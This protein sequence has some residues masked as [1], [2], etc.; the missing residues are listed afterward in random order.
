VAEY[1]RSPA[2]RALIAASAANARNG[3]E[4]LGFLSPEYGFL[5]A[6]PPLQALPTS[7]GA[8]DELAQQL[9]ELYRTL[10]LRRTLEAL[11]ELPADAAQLPD[12]YLLRASALLSILAH[13]YHRVEPTPPARLPQVLQ[14]PWE[15][16]SRRLG[17][18]TTVLSYIDLI[19]YNWRL[20]D[21]GHLHPHRVENMALLI[22]TVDNREEQIFYLTQVEIL[23]RCA[24]LVE[25][26]V[27]AQEAALRD[28]P[29]ALKAELA[30]IAERL[31]L[32]AHES[33]VK[34]DPNPT[35]ATYV[36]PVVWAKTVA[37]FAVPLFEGVQGPSGT[38]SPIFNLLDLFFGRRDYHSMLGQ[39]IMHLRTWYP[40][41]WQTFLAAV[42][43][44]STREY[45]ERKGDRELTGF[46][47]AAL[48]AYAGEDGFLGRHRLK[49][50]GYLE[51]AFK[52]GRSVTIGGFTGLF[53]DRT[54]DTV[55]AALEESRQERLDHVEAGWHQATV[56]STAHSPLGANSTARHVALYVRGAGLTYQP[57]DRCCVLPEN[58]PTLIARTLAALQATGDEVVGL[59][60]IWRDALA[61]REGYATATELPL[62]DLLRFGEIRPVRRSVARGL[63]SAT[64][65]QA[66]RRIIDARA[67]DQWELWDLLELLTVAGFDPRVLWRAHPSDRE[68]VCWVVPPLRYRMYSIVSA[69]ESGMAADEIHLTVGGMRYQTQAT[70]VSNEAT[71][72]GTAS[73]FLMSLEEGQRVAVKIVHPPRFSLP[74]DFTRPIVM[75]AGGTGLAPFRSFLQARARQPDAGPAWL[76]FATR[77][78]EELYYA[79]DL[80][81]HVANGRLTLQVALS[82]EERSVRVDD[83]GQIVLDPARSRRIDD[84]LLQEDNAAL[85]GRL[86]RLDA[87]DGGAVVYVCGRAGFADTVQRTLR[88]LLAKQLP[89]TPADQARESAKL[90][91]KLVADGRYREEVYTSYPGPTAAASLQIDASEIVLHNDA[92]RDAWVVISGRVYDLTEFLHLHPGGA[93]ILRAYLGMDA[94]HA[95][96]Q[97]LHHVRPEVDALLAMY[98]IGVVRRL[99]FGAAWTVI[100]AGSGLRFMFLADAYKAW[101]RLLYLVVEMENA[102]HLDFG[103]RQSVTTGQ[104]PLVAHTPYTLQLVLEV[105]QRFSASYLYGLSGEPLQELWTI[106]CGLGG[107][108]ENVDWM[109]EVLDALLQS[110][111]A[112]AVDSVVA[113]LVE[114]VQGDM[115]AETL[116][117]GVAATQVLEA[118]DRTFLHELKLAI[119]DGVQIFETYERDTAAH[120]GVRLLDVC[121]RLADLYASFFTRLREALQPYA[122][123]SVAARIATSTSPTL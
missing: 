117:R 20:C 62:H 48:N 70:T 100:V 7:H 46:F 31:H 27:R 112:R 95:Y 67:E 16:V 54:W 73:T 72:R 109:R 29:P 106:A 64:G 114:S 44:Y 45:I 110:E 10:R 75:I 101:V 4:N 12:T 30:G 58:V 81:R 43:A 33:L 80:A 51:L 49:V 115:D 34:I 23:A 84:L 87:N 123:V 111:A 90:F 77:T 50:Y 65:N 71:R 28:D 118:A 76:F 32:V 61:L 37:P 68:N 24:P 2:R 88:A 47:Q 22:P 59:N 19:I 53:K 97:V 98:T 57:G 60:T 122:S 108:G 15:E 74:T 83:G 26:I 79:A 66:L 113:A 104:E 18:R 69:P 56:R 89:D 39:E 52:V 107:Q 17:R 42:G 36:D 78:R 116:A 102:L 35:S 93:K 13:A 1:V 121:R 21:P 91:R 14:R 11:D 86:L 120:G 119:R 94:T 82:R 99:D 5:P 9:P 41:H 25:T 55:D 103:I 105:H 38:S 85:L 92:E 8:W 96:R 6:H 40:P 63:Y 3:H